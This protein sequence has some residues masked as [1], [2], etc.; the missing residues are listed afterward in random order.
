MCSHVNHPISVM[1]CMGLLWDLR[2]Q[3]CLEEDESS[4]TRVLVLHGRVLHGSCHFVTISW[5]ASSPQGI[6]FQTPFLTLIDCYAW[7]LISTAYTLVDSSGHPSLWYS[8]R[9]QLGRN[10]S[11][12]CRAM[13]TKVVTSAE[14]H[15]LQ[16]LDGCWPESRAGSYNTR[17]SRTLFALYAND[18]SQ[19]CG[20]CTGL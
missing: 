8:C 18:F 4:L 20:I 1:I 3:G 6:A 9:S 14:V 15:L 12:L 5:G 10:R 13:P 11:V 2:K 16:N 7:C 19:R 17:A